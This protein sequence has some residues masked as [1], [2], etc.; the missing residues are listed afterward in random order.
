MPLGVQLFVAFDHDVVAEPV[1]SRHQVVKDALGQVGQGGRVGR[2]YVHLDAAAWVEELADLQIDDGQFAIL[3]EC[4][5]RC[6]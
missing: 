1:L 2:A 5:G 3:G 4:R 6:T